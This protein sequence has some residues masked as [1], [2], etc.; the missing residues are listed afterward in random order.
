M[1]YRYTAPA[2]QCI[3]D[4]ATAL[5]PNRSKASDGTLGDYAHSQRP[6]DHNPDSRGIVH[7][8]DLTHDPVHGCDNHKNSVTHLD[9]PRLS[10]RIWNSRIYNPSIAPYWRAYTGSNPHKAHMHNSVKSGEIENNTDSWFDEIDGGF[11]MAEAD[12]VISTIGKYEQD[13]RKILIDFLVRLQK[14]SNEASR[15]RTNRIIAAIDALAQNNT[16]QART[17]LA[18]AATSE[19]VDEN[20]ASTLAEYISELDELNEAQDGGHNHP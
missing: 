10:Y 8:S 2:A 15:R 20:P 17:K 18:E 4:Q 3:L 13:T 1:P 7:A 9:D 6:S 14:K 11:T 12:R 16:D 19:D 5:Y